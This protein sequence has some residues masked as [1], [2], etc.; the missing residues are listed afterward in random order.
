[1]KE[2]ILKGFVLDDQRLK[3]GQN[4]FGKDYFKELLRRI[5]SIRVS[6]RIIYQQVTNCNLSFMQW[7]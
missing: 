3:E 4:A 5:P 1:L 6:E 7:K 2:Y